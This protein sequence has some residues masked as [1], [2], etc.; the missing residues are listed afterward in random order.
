LP[1]ERTR[2]A[3][4]RKGKAC[5]SVERILKS[6][7]GEAAS[8]EL[9]RFNGKKLRPTKTHSTNARNSRSD[10]KVESREQAGSLISSSGHIDPYLTKQN[11][12][13]G[14]AT[15]TAVNITLSPVEVHIVSR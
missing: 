2:V 12:S 10:R 14:A 3:K 7:D 9:Q 13:C 11:T 5:S 8:H 15:I 1:H 4:K 6:F